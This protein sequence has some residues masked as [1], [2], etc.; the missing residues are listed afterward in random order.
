MTYSFTFHYV[1]ILIISLKSSAFKSALFTFHYVSILIASSL[2]YLSSGPIYIPLCLYFN[3]Y[4]HTIRSAMFVFTFHYVSILMIC[5]RR[6]SLVSFSVFTF[7]YVSILIH[8]PH[9]FLFSFFSTHFLS[10]YQ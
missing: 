3:V 10:T 4:C 8:P 9:L 2:R 7:H 6:S 1:S 5:S